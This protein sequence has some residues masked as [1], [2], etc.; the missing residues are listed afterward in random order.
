MPY[1]S[2]PQREVVVQKATILAGQYP[3]GAVHQ[4]WPVLLHSSTPGLVGMVGWCGVGGWVG[5]GGGLSG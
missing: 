1:R 4:Q 5:V 3:R 2:A